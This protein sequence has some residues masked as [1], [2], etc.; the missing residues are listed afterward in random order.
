MCM[1][2]GLHGYSHEVC[3]NFFR[4]ELTLS[5]VLPLVNLPE[6]NLLVAR[7]TTYDPSPYAPNAYQLLQRRI[8]EGECCAVV[9]DEQGGHGG[10]VGVGCRVRYVLH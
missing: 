8:S 1:Y 5:H 6:P 10:V 9:G 7:S 4:L 2:S 3:G